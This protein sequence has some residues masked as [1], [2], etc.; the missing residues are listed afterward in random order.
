MS[1]NKKNSKFKLSPWA[2]Y[3]LIIGLFLLINIFGN[4]F[5]FN[6]PKQTTLSKFYQYLDSN[7]VEKVIF[8]NFLFILHFYFLYFFLEIFFFSNL[9]FF[10]IC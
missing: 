6:S 4:G 8:S 10:L 2:I 5:D 3:G 9:L 1:D 7:Q